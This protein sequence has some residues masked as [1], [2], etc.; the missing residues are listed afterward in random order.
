MARVYR[1]AEAQRLGLPGRSSLELVSGGKGSAAISLRLVE[2]APQKPGEPL[3][4]PHVHHGFEECIYVLSGEGATE[5]E[6]GLHQLKQGD[7]ILIPSE[8]RHVTRNTGSDT[9]RLLCFFPVGDV[10]SGTEEFPAWDDGR[11]GS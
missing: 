4:G 5:S 6:T 2:I 8:E 9:L 1:E 3:R 7:T 11:A 10:K